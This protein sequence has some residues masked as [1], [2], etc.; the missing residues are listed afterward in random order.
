M[1]AANRLARAWS[2]TAR[3]YSLSAPGFAGFIRHSASEI[4]PMVLSTLDCLQQS[5]VTRVMRQHAHPS[6]FAGIKRT[7][8][9]YLIYE[10]P[11]AACMAVGCPFV[12]SRSRQ[13]A[14]PP[15]STPF[16]KGVW[17]MRH[18]VI[19]GSGRVGEINS[20]SESLKGKRIKLHLAHN[21]WCHRRIPTQ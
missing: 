3:E 8:R 15:A 21:Q 7:D 5:Q 11:M 2:S 18:Q 14:C 4:V 19:I 20:S 17:I 9:S 16:G 10:N 1:R 12:R 13:P 6:W